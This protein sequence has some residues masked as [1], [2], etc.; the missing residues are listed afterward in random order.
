MDQKREN[1]KKYL[2]AAMLGVGCTSKRAVWTLPC[3]FT[4][5]AGT[6]VLQPGERHC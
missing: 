1:M 2:I 4:P 6:G 5:M 3:R